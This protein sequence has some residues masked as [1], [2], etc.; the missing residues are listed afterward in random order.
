[1]NFVRVRRRGEHNPVLVAPDAQEKIAH[2]RKRRRARQVFALEELAPIFFDTVSYVVELSGGHEDRQE[3]VSPL[4]NLP[5]HLLVRNVEAKM[6]QRFL[7]RLSMQVDRI[8]QRTVY[9]EYE[10]TSHAV[11]CI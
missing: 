9:V 4:A 10:C 8:D 6:R 11:S 3:L 2:T 5:S 1:V 7:P